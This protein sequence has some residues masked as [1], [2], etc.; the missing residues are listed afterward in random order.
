MSRN[1]FPALFAIGVGVFTGES[2]LQQEW[3]MSGISP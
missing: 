1:F 3:P 2:T